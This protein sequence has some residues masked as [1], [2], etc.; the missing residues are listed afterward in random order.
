M[1]LFTII[2]WRVA[3]SKKSLLSMADGTGLLVEEEEEDNDA[4]AA[5]AAG[6]SRS[7]SK[8]SVALVST[9]GADIEG[10]GGRKEGR[11]SRKRNKTASR[12]RIPQ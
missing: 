4:A 12:S 1:S 10:K 7:P 5:A 9:C 3:S 6:G 8:T 2:T 11:K